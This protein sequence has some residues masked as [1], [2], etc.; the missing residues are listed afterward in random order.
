M[1]PNAKITGRVDSENREVLKC[2]NENSS[3]CNRM[4][5]LASDIFA[6]IPFRL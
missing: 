1:N 2:E 5:G 4:I 6:K 3:M